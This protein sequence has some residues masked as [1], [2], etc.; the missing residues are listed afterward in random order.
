M[1]SFLLFMYMVISLS[2]SSSATNLHRLQDRYSKCQLFGIC[3]NNIEL[4][5]NVSRYVQI[6]IEI[7][8]KD[9]YINASSIYLW[10]LEI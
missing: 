1:F 10:F 8:G 9:I 5:D 2:S 6:P 7:N 3:D 4:F